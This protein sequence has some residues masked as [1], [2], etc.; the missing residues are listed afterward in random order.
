MSARPPAAPILALHKPFAHAPLVLDE[1]R[2][3]ELRKPIAGRI[4]ER[5]ENR[6]AVDDR[7][8]EHLRLSVVGTLDLLGRVNEATLAEQSRELEHVLIADR[9]AGKV[10]RRQRRTCVRPPALDL[11]DRLEQNLPL[12]ERSR[13]RHRAVAGL[14]FHRS[15]RKDYGATLV[16]SDAPQS[17]AT[18]YQHSNREV[19]PS[20]AVLDVAIG[21]AE[22]DDLR[23]R[24][25][26]ASGRAVV[27]LRF[28][29]HPKHKVAV[30]EPVDHL[31]RSTAPPDRCAHGRNRAVRRDNLEV[32]A[33]VAK[34]VS[35]ALSHEARIAQ[36]SAFETS[37]NDGRG[38]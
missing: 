31:P 23:T 1:E 30:S 8:R 24:H 25:D 36:G 11:E 17:T 38:R 21:K 4:V 33:W 7:Q 20:R 27:A 16:R 14:I 37:E 19:T 3:A 29:R 26:S 12:P 10:H 9:D 15:L 2:G 6:L 22:Q 28:W 32:A 5:P 13:R 18:T 35:L 34:H